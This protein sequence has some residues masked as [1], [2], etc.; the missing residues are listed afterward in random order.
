MVCFDNFGKVGKWTIDSFVLILSQK[1]RK[2]Y[3]K[4]ILFQLQI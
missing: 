1:Q 2:K 4:W 3:Q